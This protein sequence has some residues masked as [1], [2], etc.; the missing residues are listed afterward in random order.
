M[1]LIDW[2]EETSC[3]MNT[4][5][6][7]IY[8]DYV[9]NFKLITDFHIRVADTPAELTNALYY[10]KQKKILESQGQIVGWG[11]SGRAGAPY[12]TNVNFPQNA[13]SIER[14]PEGTKYDGHWEDGRWN[15]S[16]ADD[17]SV[18]MLRNE[19]KRLWRLHPAPVYF[20]DNLA[21]PS[22]WGNAPFSW[23][24][25]CE[26]IKSL[27]EY[28]N[29]KLQ[30]RCVFNIAMHTGFLTPKET[31]LLIE[32]V[33][34]DIICLEQPFYTGVR[35]DLELFQKAKNKFRELLD[36][37]VG[38]AWIPLG[39]QTVEILWEIRQEL[40]KT[41]NIIYIVSGLTTPPHPLLL[42]KSGQGK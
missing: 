27:R 18:E 14:L 29:K 9:K 19:I 15:V 40:I 32:A 3:W 20:V 16:L 28:A 4:Y 36:A 23:E 22:A 33:G 38:F 39:D 35:N 11:I 13:M 8:R 24:D 1:A 6:P 30:A 41:R 37:G 26:H 42:E 10:A 17:Y 21:H 25:T 12:T 34:Q 7:L 2:P 5:E 31:V